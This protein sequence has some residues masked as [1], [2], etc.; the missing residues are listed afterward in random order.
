MQEQAKLDKAREQDR[1]LFDFDEDIDHL[2][3]VDDRYPANK[4]KNNN[5][6]QGQESKGKTLR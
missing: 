2:E 3:D 4:V 1:A 6:I 5:L